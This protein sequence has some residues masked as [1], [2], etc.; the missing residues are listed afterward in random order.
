MTNKANNTDNPQHAFNINTLLKTT[1]LS[2][3]ERNCYGFNRVNYYAKENLKIVLPQL[4]K[5]LGTKI[6]LSNGDKSSKFAPE[7]LKIDFIPEIGQ[8]LRTYLHFNYKGLYLF[9]DITL[10]T[11]DYE[12]GGYGAAY[13]KTDLR[14]ADINEIGLLTK[15]ENYNN[16]IS[17]YDLDN[18]FNP[19]EAKQ[20]E[21][22]IE[23][24][25][26]EADALKSKY[27][28]IIILPY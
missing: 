20:A 24:L 21:V 18:I 23:Q 4:T 3:I 2:R 8:S 6:K 22:K 19:V 1:E 27:S 15:I 17:F 26:R 9:T 16:I 13:Y 5:F 12:G 25:K 14:I 10:K 7:L 11:Q 28:N